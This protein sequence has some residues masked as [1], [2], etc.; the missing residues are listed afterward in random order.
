MPHGFRTWAPAH[1]GTDLPPST[2]KPDGVTEPH[3]TCQDTS[4][5]WGEAR[6]SGVT[7]ARV[8]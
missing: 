4:E 5:E 7:G 2:E 1:D 3:L 6:S 8:M